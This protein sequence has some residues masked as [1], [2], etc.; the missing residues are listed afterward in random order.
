MALKL[1]VTERLLLKVTVHE[2]VPLQ[3]P[4]QPENAEP[5]LGAAVKVTLVSTA[6]LCVHVDPQSMPLGVLLML[7]LPAPARVIVKALVVGV[8]V[9]V[10]LIHELLYP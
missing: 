9:L 2:P 5:T 10:V 3:S 4:D 8:D 6:K 1:A 7:P